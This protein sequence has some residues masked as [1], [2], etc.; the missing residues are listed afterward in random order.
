MEDLFS[1]FR[2]ESSPKRGRKAPVEGIF[3]SPEMFVGAVIIFIIA[4]VLA[5]SIGVEQG[6]RIARS[7][8]VVRT[9]KKEVKEK[10]SVKESKEVKKP[11]KAST[12]S[13]REVETKKVT[14]VQAKTRPKKASGKYAVQLVVYKDKRYAQREM[15]YLKKQKYPFFKEVKNGKIILS[16]GPFATMEEAK[17]AEKD[18]KRRYKDCFIKLIKR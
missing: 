6:K 15:E 7:Q 8:V 10:K 5:F 11:P 2:S 4:V 13:K 3:I 16:A 14:T 18:L 12:T 1:N 17:K 9:A